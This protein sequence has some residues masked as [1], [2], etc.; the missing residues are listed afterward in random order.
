MLS[1]LELILKSHRGKYAIPHPVAVF[2]G[3]YW[4]LA[5]QCF[6][7][8]Y[9]GAVHGTEKGLRHALGAAVYDVHR[10]WSSGEA[11]PGAAHPRHASVC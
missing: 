5:G 8:R 2:L 11:S 4:L 3:V 6:L 10:F 1:G 7:Y 9:V